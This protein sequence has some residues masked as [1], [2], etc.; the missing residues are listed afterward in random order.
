MAVSE[1][2]ADLARKAWNLGDEPIEVVHH[3]IDTNF[4]KPKEGL[5]RKPAV[6][7]VGRL[8][9]NKGISVLAEAL[10]EVVK[11]MP[12]IQF[13][14]IGEDKKSNIANKTWGDLLKGKVP[15]KNICILGK[16]NEW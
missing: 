5:T 15:S 1:S 11:R 7:Y 10:P 13:I 2:Y 8:E 9:E 14:F 3:G 6:L 12:E 16:L 4:F